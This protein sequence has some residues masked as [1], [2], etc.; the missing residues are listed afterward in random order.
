LSLGKK[1]T[2]GKTKKGQTAHLAS[3]GKSVAQN[4]SSSRQIW[5]RRRRNNGV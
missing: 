5:K 4:G 2:V 1:E 3:E